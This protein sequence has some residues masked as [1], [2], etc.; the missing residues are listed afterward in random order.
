L[1]TWANVSF[2]DGWHE[3]FDQQ[4]AAEFLHAVRKEDWNADGDPASAVVRSW[5]HD[6]SQSFDRLY[7]GNPLGLICGAAARSP[8]AAAILVGPDPIFAAIE[9]HRQ[10]WAALC[11]DCSALD[12]A[13]FAGD[14]KAEQELDRL[15]DAAD[16]ATDGLIDIVPTTIAGASALL[17]YAA[18]HI[19]SG[20]EWAKCYE[21]DEEPLSDSRRQHGITWEAILHRNLAKALPRMAA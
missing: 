16:A 1:V 11:A 20:S 17:A 10:A 2:R 3:H 19:S 14:Q 4:R 8:A 7:N 13:A 6:H 9:A 5:L 18:D 21:D 12:E 15:N